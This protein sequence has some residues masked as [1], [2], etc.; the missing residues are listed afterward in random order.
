MLTA[1]SSPPAIPARWIPINGRYRVK[2]H[3]SCIDEQHPALPTEVNVLRRDGTAS[4]HQVTRL[5]Q[6]GDNPIV[7]VRR[8]HAEPVPGYPQPVPPEFGWKHSARRSKLFRPNRQGPHATVHRI[9]LHSQTLW[10]FTIR[11]QDGKTDVACAAIPTPVRAQALRD[12]E[13]ALRSMQ[14]QRNRHE[15]APELREPHR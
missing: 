8:T 5:I 11:A 2:L 12:C 10:G 4:R 9:R 1:D 15:E 14:T 6:G 13:D 3:G 7:A